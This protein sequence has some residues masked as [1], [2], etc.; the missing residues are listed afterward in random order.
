M[1][2]KRKAPTPTLKKHIEE[3]LRQVA[4][5]VES[6]RIV[7]GSCYVYFSIQP[8]Q[9]EIQIC[10]LFSQKNIDCFVVKNFKNNIIGY[11]ILYK[12]EPLIKSSEFG[13]AFFYSAKASYKKMKVEFSDSKFRI[14]SFDASDYFFSVKWK[15]INP[16]ME[17]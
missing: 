14:I 7:R 4:Q 16:S 6:Q 15:S 3:E 12:K 5:H 17:A 8:S 13:S 2:L 1:A 10:F 11:L 9:E